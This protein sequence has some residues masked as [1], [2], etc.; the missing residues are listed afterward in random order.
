MA[1]ARNI[2]PGF[3]LNDELSSLPFEDRLLF[4]GLWTLADRRGRLED[5]PKRIKA[6]I[7]PY[8]GV[9]VEAMLQALADSPERFIVRYE[10]DGTRY[11]QVTNFER[12][13]SPHKN[14]V[15]SNIPAP[16]LHGASTVQALELYGATRAESVSPLLIAD[17]L[18]AESPLLKEESELEPN[19]SLSGKP[20]VAPLKPTQDTVSAVVGFLNAI[21]GTSYKPNSRA[22]KNK[23]EARLNEGFTLDDFK[24]V[25]LKKS[26]EWLDSPEYCK[27]LR[28]ETLFGTK[29]EGYLNQL[30][31]APPKK[32]GNPY[33]DMLKEGETNG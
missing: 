31:R 23:I 30:N 17:C 32:A 8:D 25:I 22:T 2:K 24:S 6:A 33:L 13:Q 12:H 5:R 29:F 9:D 16:E 7:F 11:I 1:R 19:G 10:V 14:E 18:I 26:A 27:F 3:F 28:P 4:I 20:D 15:D 21:C